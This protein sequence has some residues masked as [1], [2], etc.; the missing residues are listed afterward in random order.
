MN[1]NSKILFLI[2][3]TYPYGRGEEFIENEIQLIAGSF[4]KIYVISQSN[5]GNITRKIPENCESVL[6]NCSSRNIDNLWFLLHYRNLK[7]IF[8]EFKN[9]NNKNLQS[10]KELIR[11]QQIAHCVEKEIRNI[12]RL[13]KIEY[14]NIVLYS[15]WFHTGSLAISNFKRKYPDIRAVCRAHRFDL[16]DYAG[17]QYY[18][19]NILKYID[20]VV[21]CSQEGLVYLQE[22][23][24]KYTN[25]FDCSYLGTRPYLDKSNSKKDRDRKTIISI[26]YIRPVKRVE[27]LIKALSFFDSTDDIEWIHIGDGPERMQIEELAKVSLKIHFKFIGHLSNID[28]LSFL[29][30]NNILCLVNLSESEGIPVSMMEVQSFGIPII[31][32][33]VGGVSEIVS[34]ENGILL[35]N[36]PNSIEVYN[37]I[38][39]MISLRVDEYEIYKKNSYESWKNNF[40]ADINYQHFIDK[41]LITND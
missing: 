33:S 37:A 9:T 34:N 2:T 17:P 24:F 27:L 14:K 28:V 12:V 13:N 8:Q 30:N 19:N 1:N 6:I 31:A 32:T 3:E 7:L 26:S 11:F 35:S 23:Y 15:Y 36:N 41:F 4:K 16:Y 5:N 21:A 29:S 40:N 20:K 10:L 38:K 18:K 25:K 22:K 39:K